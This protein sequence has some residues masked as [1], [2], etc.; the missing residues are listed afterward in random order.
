M[1]RL[2]PSDIAWGRAQGIAGVMKSEA[3]WENKPNH[4][5]HVEH[6]IEYA[7]A[8]GEAVFQQMKAYIDKELPG[9][10]QKELSK[11]SSQVKVVAKVDEKSLNEAKKK[12]SDLFKSIFH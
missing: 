2:T 12:I 10:I 9:M 5:R 6:Q 7:N 3:A 4:M 8:V 1:A 11:P